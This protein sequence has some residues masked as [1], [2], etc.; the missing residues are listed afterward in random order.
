V[1][2]PSDALIPGVPGSEPP[3]AQEPTE[4]R[5]PLPPKPDQG[6]PE[7]VTP[8]GARTGLDPTSKSQ[9]GEHLTTATAVRLHDTDHSLKAGD[10]GP[11]LLQD[12]H[13]REKIMH[14]DHERIPERV[15]HARGA[16]VHGV[17]KAYGSA[18]TVCKADFLKK[19]KETPVF[20]RF[21]TVLGSRGSADTV[22]DTRG[23]ATKFYTEQGNYD[24]V[25]NNIPVFFIQD[26]IKFPDVIHAGKP[27]PDR[28]IPQAQSAHDT[29]WDFVSLHTE[30][31]HHTMWNMS[32]RGIPRSYR[33]MEGFGVH[34]F[35]LENEAGET[36]L[37]KL[38]WKPVLGVHSLVWEEAQIA[39]GV[40][41]DFH[42]RDLYD[43]IESGAFPQWE[44][45]IQAM[46][47]TPDQTFMGIDL[48]D[49]TKIVP[50]ELA[51]VQPVGILTL[52]RN[53]TNFFAEVEQ[54]AFHTGHLVPGID[55]TNDPLLQARN[56]SYLDTQLTRLG[57]PN[58]NQIPVNRPHAPV[59]DM[60]RDG[61]H[62]HAVH[63]GVAPYR[64]NSLDGGNPFT[65]TAESGAYVEVPV[66]VAEASKVRANPASFDDHYSQVRLFWQSMTP[67]E[68]THIVDA[69]TFEL[70]KCYEQAVK[71]RQLRCLAEID[72]GLC[73]GVAAGLG[74][75]VPAP[76]GPLATVQPSPA[77]SQ[78][79]GEWPPDGRIVGIV[80]DVVTPA[81]LDGVEELREALFAAGAVPFVVAA[82]GG[83]LPNGVV[84]QRT[85][86]TVRSIELDAV[87]VAGCPQ[88]PA[89]SGGG[90]EANPVPAG[91]DGRV[92]LLLQEAF[93]H[94]KAIG[95]WG[96]GAQALARAGI[97]PDSPGVVAGADPASTLTGVQ[98]AMARHRAWERFVGAL[99]TV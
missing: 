6:T 58:F 40:D 26:G 18:E 88:P 55:A 23:F 16:G 53:P 77:L 10:R 32:D 57:G 13:L 38:H 98:A 33:M 84:A 30:A 41:P 22:R 90:P 7:T 46:P 31:Q 63:G 74:L 80:V 2:K 9:Q 48:L 1:T 71:E 35:R 51:E 78:V 75:E 45:G 67:I 96:E 34:T 60:F 59:N 50:E 92:A 5:N 17:F 52:N 91:L 56:F 36:V 87:L 47:D 8:T 29:F 86:A 12:H 21:S 43:A 61:F 49:P 97:I 95:A 79:G 54:V 70:G 94:G 66:V 3:S 93:R 44:L 99:P 4:P 20:T 83:Q 82:H 11:T 14:F 28:E 37:A 25:A 73:A 72:P 69:Y 89:S 19:N 68:K 27:H 62:Q 85:F 76:S 15:V 81:S 64:P 65:A 24:L 42:R 39:A